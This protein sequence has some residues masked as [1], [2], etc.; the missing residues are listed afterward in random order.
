MALQFQGRRLSPVRVLIVAAVIAALVA[1]GLAFWHRAND[2]AAA[3]DADQWFGAYVDATS[4]PFYDI[5]ASA[6]PEQRVVL[7]FVVADPEDDCA[8]S[9][10]GYYSMD[11]AAEVFDLDRRAARVNAAGGQI[12]VSTGGL[13]NDELATACKDPAA[14]AAAYRAVLDRYQST[15]LD[16][17]IEGDDLSDAEAGQRRVEAVLQLQ[18]DTD[19]QLWLTLPAATFGLAPEGVAEVQRMLDAGVRIDG[20]NLM[21]MNFGQTRESGQSMATASIQAAQTAHQQLDELYQAK[22]QKLGER[23][24]WRKIGVTPMIGQNDLLG[25]VFSLEDAVELNRFALAQGVGRVSFWSAN[26]DA[27]CGE[28]YP[29]L[30]RVS[31]NCS[32]VAQDTGQFASL[33]SAGLGQ[34]T[35][36]VAPSLESSGEK[37][38]VETAIADDPDASPYPIWNAQFAYVKGDRTVWRKNVYEAKWWNQNSAPDAPAGKDQPQPWSLVGP[39]LPGDKPAAVLEA[40]AGLYPSWSP[41]KVYTKDDRVLFEGRVVQAKW[42]NTAQSPEAAL[43]GS[44][45]SAWMVLDN[46]TVRKLIDKKPAKTPSAPSKASATSPAAEN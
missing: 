22:G 21:T 38:P 1:G 34:Q 9:W 23:S 29:D 11:E 20:V 45:D 26:R 37:A 19:F 25:E 18:Q 10:G 27:G 2:S 32:G 6:A 7:G 16:L 46:A 40:P 36:A 33:L 41:E 30:N 42:W 28:T 8:P 15:T 12:V 31:N 39:V 24:L 17:D 14:T 35:P 13:L 43:Q 4:T 3:A 44:T 5:G